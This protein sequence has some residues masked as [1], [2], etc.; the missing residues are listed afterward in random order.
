MKRKNGIDTSRAFVE[1]Y[2]ERSNR[3]L[4]LQ[5]LST[6]LV[7]GNDSRLDVVLRRKDFSA[8]EVDTKDG[9]RFGFKIE[10][11]SSAFRP[12]RIGIGQAANL[13]RIHLD[14][15][16]R[17]AAKYPGLAADIFNTWWHDSDIVN[18][19]GTSRPRKNK[20][21]P[22]VHRQ[23]VRSFLPANGD[24]GV[25]RAI[26]SSQYRIID[27]HDVASAALDEIEKRDLPEI[28]IRGA[29]SDSRM[30]LD[31]YTNIQSEISFPGKGRGHQA[32]RVPCGAGIRLKN[33]DVG[34]ST[35]VVEPTLLVTTCSNLLI[36]TESLRQIHVGADYSE[37]NILSPQTIRK[38]NEALFAK[39]RDVV[40]STLV[41]REFDR[42]V[43]LFSENAGYPVDDSKR[44]IENVT[45]RFSIPEA[46]GESIL[47]RFA[48]EAA[49]VGS[50]RF[51]LAQAITAEGREHQETDFEKAAFLQEVGS[52]V[53]RMPQET[54]ARQIEVATK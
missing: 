12:T 8:T 7:R 52:Q 48:K 47:S 41:K 26:L 54:F 42:I 3:I 33:S 29:L 19:I 9:P 1:P 6:A 23:M 40:R 14:D 5:D 51:A 10:G 32:V 34:V 36:S 28:Q 16:K 37:M 15:F 31:V 53:L 35:L 18:R 24:P 13:T 30:Y 20:I 17:T 25:V 27:N 11:E 45:D 44:V 50:N 22:A 38:M 46:A 39:L 2:G 43:D 49:E 4:N 21:D